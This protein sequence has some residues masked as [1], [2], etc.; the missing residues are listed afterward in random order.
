MTSVMGVRALQLHRALLCLGLLALLAAPEPCPAQVR[1]LTLAQMQR[2][3]KI[4]A[5]DDLVAREVMTRGLTFVPDSALIERLV[6]EGAGKATLDALKERIPRANLQIQTQQG[7]HVT[8]DSSDMGPVGP[9]G[10]I[11]LVGILAGKH[12]VTVRHDGYTSKTVQISL[13]ANETRNLPLSLD[14]A[15]GYLTIK[16]SRPGA[17]ITV[18][19]LGTYHNA[20]TAL[21]VQPGQYQVAVT[22]DGMKAESRTLEVVAGQQANLEFSLSPDPDYVQNG[23]REATRHLD[24]GDPRGAMQI[25]QRL[26][27][28]HPADG[29]I[30]AFEARLYLQSQ[31]YGSFYHRATQALLDHGTL[32]FVLFHEHIGLAG[33]DM[34]RALLTLT[35][36]SLSYDAMAAPC[37]YQSLNVPLDGIRN[38]QTTGSS[39]GFFETHHLM[40]GTFLLHLVIKDPDNPKAK[41]PIQL[42]FAAPESRLVNYNNEQYISSPIGSKQ[43]LDAIAGIIQKAAQRNGN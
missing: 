26:L 38:V 19:G 22:Q 3:I 35:S 36:D 43:E 12:T 25:A 14:W 15:G 10:H 33:D 7:S 16:V 23:L 5:P 30:E 6:T 21:A 42:S 13:A 32:R 11:I 28:T 27:A 2:L 37:K 39:G 41:H 40:Q 31:D 20:I 34:H 29:A 17:T 8:V 4:H 1:A 18:S 24:G 9:E